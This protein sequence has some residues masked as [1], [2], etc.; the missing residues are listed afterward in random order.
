MS[1]FFN[2]AARAELLEQIAYY[3][4]RRPGLGARFLNGFVAAMERICEAPD[5]HRIEY[6][7]AIRRHRIAGFRYNILY[8]QIDGDAIEVL[9]VAAHRLRPG[10]W[11]DR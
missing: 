8:R 3:N 2:P 1:Y 10:Y 4:S 11:H 5:R 7:P 6:P 9:A